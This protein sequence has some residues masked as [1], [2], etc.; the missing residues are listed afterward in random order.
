MLAEATGY[1]HIVRGITLLFGVVH[2]VLVGQ[3]SHGAGTGCAVNAPSV[4]LAC[5][6]SPRSRWSFVVK[7]RWDGCCVKNGGRGERS[8]LRKRLE[9]EGKR[10]LARD[11]S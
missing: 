6:Q 10:A 2:N 7:R 4:L 11:A 8:R 9:K 5:D 1:A 3:E